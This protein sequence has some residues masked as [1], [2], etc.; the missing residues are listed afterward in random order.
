MTSSEVLTAL[1]HYFSTWEE[2][3]EAIASRRYA[4]G[5]AGRF[6]GSA[7]AAFELLDERRRGDSKMEI[8]DEK[9]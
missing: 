8:A 5:R 4:N 7:A 2:M 6:S 1:R 9:G 3:R